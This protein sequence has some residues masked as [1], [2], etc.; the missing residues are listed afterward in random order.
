[1]SDGTLLSSLHTTA[2]H[3]LRRLSSPTGNRLPL[4]RKP[5]KPFVADVGI[6]GTMANRATVPGRDVK[7]WD[8]QNSYLLCTYFPKIAKEEEGFGQRQFNL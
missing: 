2:K 1:M 4:A 7:V 8:L 5:D 3:S 6:E